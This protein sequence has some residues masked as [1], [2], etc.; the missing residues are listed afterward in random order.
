MNKAFNVTV[1]VERHVGDR[2]LLRVK[3]HVLLGVS[4]ALDVSVADSGSY[5]EAYHL[6]ICVLKYFVAALA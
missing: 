5:H 6:T 1:F 2:A 4:E 3:D